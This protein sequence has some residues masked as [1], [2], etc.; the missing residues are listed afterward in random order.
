MSKNGDVIL[1][2]GKGHEEYQEIK[3]VKHQFDDKEGRR[4]IF[5][6]SQK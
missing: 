1:V 6:I 4:D 3:G 2:A 5:G